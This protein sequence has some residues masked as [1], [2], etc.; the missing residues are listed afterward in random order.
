MSFNTATAHKANITIE[1][2]QLQAIVDWCERNCVS[3][4]WYSGE[5]ERWDSDRL[6]YGYEFYFES[7]K[8]YFAFMIWKK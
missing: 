3:E 5:H 4:F 1:F 2:G 7:D 6:Y 8:D